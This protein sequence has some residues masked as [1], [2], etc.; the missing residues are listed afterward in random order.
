MGSQADEAGLD[1]LG[2]GVR[3]YPPHCHMAV[4]LSGA[5]ESNAVIS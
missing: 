4:G 3:S 2:G 1:R 5:R